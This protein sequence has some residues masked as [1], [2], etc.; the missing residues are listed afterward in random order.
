[1]AES[2]NIK[3]VIG[4]ERITPISVVVL[5]CANGETKEVQLKVGSDLIGGPRYFNPREK[6][7]GDVVASMLGNLHD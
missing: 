1:M 4:Q 5:P 7:L 2:A 6:K 3:V